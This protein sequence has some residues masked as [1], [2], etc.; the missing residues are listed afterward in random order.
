M[1]VIVAFHAHKNGR[2]L[3]ADDFNKLLL[4]QLMK[5]LQLANHVSRDAKLLHSSIEERIS[6]A[7]GFLLLGGRGHL[8]LKQRWREHKIL[9][10]FANSANSAIL[11]GEVVSNEIFF[12]PLVRSTCLSMSKVTQTIWYYL[13]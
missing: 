4:R 8:A 2:S 9:A 7:L 5:L 12:I 10:N 3:F 1:L 13:P 6:L 11:S